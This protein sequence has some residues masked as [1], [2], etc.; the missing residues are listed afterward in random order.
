[1]ITFPQVLNI[2]ILLTRKDLQ[3]NLKKTL[4]SLII[5][6]SLIIS[7]NANIC[8]HLCFNLSNKALTII[9]AGDEPPAPDPEYDYYLDSSNASS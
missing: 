3:I 6:I 9:A 7:I 2:H 5:L 4:L 1:M 8:N